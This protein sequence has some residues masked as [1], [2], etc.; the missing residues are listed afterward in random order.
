MPSCFEGRGVKL[1]VDTWSDVNNLGRH[2]S[3]NTILQLKLYKSA[4]YGGTLM[5]ILFSSWRPCKATIIATS[6]INQ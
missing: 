2:I 1:N 5:H 4:E 6:I 3:G